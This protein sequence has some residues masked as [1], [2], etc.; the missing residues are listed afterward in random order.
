MSPTMSAETVDELLDNLNLNIMNIFPQTESTMKKH[1]DSPWI[2]N[3]WKLNAEKKHLLFFV[4]IY[5]CVSLPNHQN[6]PLSS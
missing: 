1:H 3:A 4:K 5:L 2:E 6:S